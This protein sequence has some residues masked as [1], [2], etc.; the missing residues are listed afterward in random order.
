MSYKRKAGFYIIAALLLAISV[1]VLAGV[2]G[3]P[4][5]QGVLLFGV[6]AISVFCGYNLG[7]LGT[8]I[9]LEG[10]SEEQTVEDNREPFIT[11]MN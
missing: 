11:T 5:W 10:F 3:A 7:V 8:C 6:Q 4:W 9:V 1:V 2:L